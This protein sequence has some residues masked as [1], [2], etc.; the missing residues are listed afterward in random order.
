MTYR[1]ALLRIIACG[2]IFS[3]LTGCRST[4]STTDVWTEGHAEKTGIG[5]WLSS[6]SDF[7]GYWTP[8]EEDILNL[9]G[10]LDSFLRE[11]SEQFNSQPPVWEQIKNYKRQYAGLII[12]GKQLIYGNF[13]CTETGVDWREEWVI[14]MDGGDCF[15]Q[16]RFDME[17]GEFMNLMVNGEA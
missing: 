14:V 8:T 12:N 11:N 6:E 9:E 7:G 2:A 4:S 16:L 10:K 13:F 1:R 17:S 5:T 3:L 15:F